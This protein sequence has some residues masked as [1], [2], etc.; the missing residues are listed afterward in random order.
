MGDLTPHFG[1]SEF[2]VSNTADR[3][4]IY[5]DPTPEHRERIATM[6]APV[7]EAIRDRLKRSVVIMSG[8][9]SAA[10]NKAVGGVATSAHCLG[11]AADIT[12]AGM[13]ALALAQ[14]IASQPGIMADIDQLILETSRGVV[15]VSVDPRRR[16]QVLTQSRAAGSP[17]RQG[18]H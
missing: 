4:K 7:L 5:N 1:M 16:M 6:L 18:L 3:L 8:Y 13:S 15:H 12:A 2:L 11:Y 10:L 14:W 17:V 9:R